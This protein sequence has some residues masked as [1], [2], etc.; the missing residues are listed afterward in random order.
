MTR[1]WPLMLRRTHEADRAALVEAHKDTIRWLHVIER[2]F[3]ATENERLREAVRRA[4]HVVQQVSPGLRVPDFGPARFMRSD[5]A[6]DQ[7][8]VIAFHEW[9]HREAEYR[10][11]QAADWLGKVRA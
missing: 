7:P 4:E 3:L 9:L 1:R 8:G 6:P 10:E 11:A 2:T 5:D